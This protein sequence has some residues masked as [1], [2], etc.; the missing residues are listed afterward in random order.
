[1]TAHNK[2]LRTEYTK[3][4]TFLN[5]FN[6][7]YEGFSRPVALYKADPQTG[8]RGEFTALA[9][10]SFMLHSARKASQIS[11][12]SLFGFVIAPGTISITQS[13]SRKS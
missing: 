5:T 9:V 6:M 10:Y 7:G 2:D 11:S 13:I 12:V 8:H 4:G 1:M 3:P